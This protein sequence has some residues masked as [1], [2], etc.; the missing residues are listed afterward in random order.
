MAG[1]SSGDQNCTVKTEEGG[2]EEKKEEGREGEKKKNGSLCSLS[3]VGRPVE[4]VTM[5]LRFGGGRKKRAQDSEEDQAVVG[6][7]EREEKLGLE[8]CGIHG[9]SDDSPMDRI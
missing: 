8:R 6:G 9:K 7:R 4:R 3:K 1:L 2:K 5:S